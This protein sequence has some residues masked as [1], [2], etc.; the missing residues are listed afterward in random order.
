MTNKLAIHGGS[1]T[2]DYSFARHNPLGQ[3]EREA[4]NA[5]MD[6]GV[7]SQFLGEW[8]DDFYGGSRVRE[9]E[10]EAALHFNVK[11]AISVNSLTSGLIAAV[12]ALGIS[13]GDEVIVS[14]WTMS[15]S[16][17]APLW[18]NAIPV[19]SDIESETF[20][21][22]PISIEKNITPY[23]KAIIA[24]D[25]F[26][27]SADMHAINKIA[28]EHGLLVIS[29]CA[30]SPNAKYR[31]K[32][33]GT[34]SDIGGYSFNFHKHIH[35]GEGGLIV[36]DDDDL[37]ER[38]QLIRNHAEN[39]ADGKGLQNITNMVGGNFRLGELEASIAAAQL[40][41]LD[42][43]T[44]RTTAIGTQLSEGLSELDGLRPPITKGDCTHVYC[45]FPLIIYPQEIGISREAICRALV[46]EGI[47][48]GQGYANIHLLPVFQQKIAYGSKGFPWSSSEYRGDVK[49]DKGICPV[50]EQLHDQLFLSFGVSLYDWSEK[51]ID[52]T[53]QAFHKVWGNLDKLT[54]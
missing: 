7:L 10:K 45:T 19:F 9:F 14:P 15:A 41:K 25:I 27:H 49:Y 21:I 4:V 30:Q 47:P 34:L 36:T 1:K 28:K 50:A 39:V 35:C 22:D 16:A 32:L 26:G 11:H 8:H 12:G 38:L 44:D 51:D 40:M 23:T 31:G 52:L 42:G 2:I 48:L 37:A 18:W 17:I 3:E 29:D 13:P 53:I 43:I 46:G 20:T 54:E 6:S 24:V 33:A 5:V